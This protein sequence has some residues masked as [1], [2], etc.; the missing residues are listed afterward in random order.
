MSEEEKS[1][2]FIKVVE[3]E[4]FY[5]I[6][7]YGRSHLLGKFQ[8]RY[9]LRRT[10]RNRYF[11]YCLIIIIKDE[12]IWNHHCKNPKDLRDFFSSYCHFFS[13]DLKIVKPFKFIGGDEDVLFSPC[14]GIE[15]R[16][17]FEYFSYLM[18]SNYRTLF[19][20]RQ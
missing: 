7:L 4:L 11:K 8:M 2:L 19:N 18:D 13:F 12:N 9:E 5:S 10:F 14:V 17:S 1:L 20:R 15:N 6:N 16:I 3:R